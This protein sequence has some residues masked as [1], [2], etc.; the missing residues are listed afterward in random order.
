MMTLAQLYNLGLSQHIDLFD[1]LHLPEGSPLDRDTL[2][3]VIMEKCGL[4]IPLYADAVVMKSAIT[5][6]SAKHQYTFKHVGKIFDA[7]YSPIE[8]T[9]KY[10]T[11]NITRDRD[12]SDDTT[13]SSNKG[14]NASTTNT[15]IHGG[16]DV[17]HIDETTS[18]DN[19]DDYQPKDHT[20]TTADYNSTI[21]DSGSLS[22][23]TV[24]NGS[25]NKTIGE[26]ET[27]ETATHM[28]GN[29]GTISNFRLQSEEYELLNGFN[30]FDF[31]AG[32]F[33]NELTLY[34]Y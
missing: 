5:L 28:H 30:P 33:E 34:V 10:E 4:N 1:G 19:V 20:E 16:R 31:L 13:T 7:E 32:L 12:V 14:E 2:V 23:S 21:T 26:D 17:T 11:I 9:D 3:N 18:A 6:W 24:L 22:K 15:N 29:I 27:T 8:N 25:N